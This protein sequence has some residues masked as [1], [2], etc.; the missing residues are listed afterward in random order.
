MASP[1]HLARHGRPAHPRELIEHPCIRLRFPNGTFYRWEFAQGDERVEV[2]VDGPLALGDM[3]L[4]VQAAEQGLGLAFVYQQYAQQA[5]A[6]GR[7][8][9]VLD[10]WRPAETGFFLYYPSQRLVP[11]GLRAF[12]ELVRERHP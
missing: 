9:T 12:I 10:D 4:M 5:L 7:L 11:A 8:I 2:A 1:E 6:A 3:R